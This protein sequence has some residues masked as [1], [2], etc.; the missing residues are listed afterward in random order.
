MSAEQPGGLKWTYFDPD[1][2]PAWV[3][4]MDYP[5]APE[6]S[7]A[8]HAAIDLN[9][10]GYPYPQIEQAAFE[11]ATDFWHSEL[12]WQVD[13]SWVFS[14]PDVI[15]GTK[16][17]IERLTKPG[18]P[19][20]LHTPVYFPFFGMVGRAGRQLVEVPSHVDDDGTYRLDLD[21]IERAFSHGAGSIV[22]CN[23]WNPTGR[24]FERSELENLIQLAER[25]ESRVISDEIHAPIVYEGHEHVPAAS[26]APEVVVTVTSASK[27]FD[28]PG[29]KCAQVVLTNGN[30]RENWASYFTP[31]TVGVGTLGLIAAEAAYG[32]SKDWYRDL[33]AGLQT[34]KDLL[35]RELPDVLPEV[36]LNETQG[37]Y[38]AWLD[39]SAYELDD[40]AA[41]LLEHAR[42]AL[43]GGAQFRGSSSHFGRLNFATT[44]D[45]LNEILARIRGALLA[46]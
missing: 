15:E 20:V 42:V 10:T 14:V 4:E 23:P 46:L 7:N 11:A 36:K 16:R 35:V 25:Y 39:F 12:G 8:L 34:N 32:R 45:R 44:P 22:L 19:V 6:I 38:L 13:Q 17:A 27:T 18:S 21:G 40:P 41:Y 37:T 3:A 43:T 26:I 28:L 29:L 2:V 5:L 1:V 31:E 24:V 30:D 9:L 33:V